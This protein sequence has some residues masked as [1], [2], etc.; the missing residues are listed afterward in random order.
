MN[1]NGLEIKTTEKEDTKKD[2]QLANE[3]MDYVNENKEN[4][5]LTNRLAFM[6][7]DKLLNNGFINIEKSD[8]TVLG[9][10]VVIYVGGKTYMSTRILIGTMK[11]Y[12]KDMPAYYDEDSNM[13]LR[14]MMKFVAKTPIVEE[15]A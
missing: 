9:D 14:H 3:L 1:I 6:G 11:R 15:V 5:R 13:I 10:Y 8:N 12:F 4:K 7:N 2:V